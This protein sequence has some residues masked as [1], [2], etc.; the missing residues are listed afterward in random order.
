MFTIDSRGLGLGEEAGAGDLA[1]IVVARL[2]L[3]R[4]TCCCRLPRALPETRIYPIEK[5][6]TGGPKFLGFTV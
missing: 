3:F 6:Q 2:G 1:H 5:D 4:R